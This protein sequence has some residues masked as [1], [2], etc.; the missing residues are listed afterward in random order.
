[1][2]RDRAA[3]FVCGVDDLSDGLVVGRLE[4]IFDCVFIDEVQDLA[5][6]DLDLLDK[7]FDSKMEVICVGDPRQATFSTNRGLKNSKYAGGAGFMKWL[8]EPG[9]AKRL[10]MEERTQS[11]RCN[12]SIC[13]FADALYPDL[14]KTESVDVAAT[15]H[16]GIFF[17]SEEEVPE[18]VTTYA[19][20]VLR[21]DKRAKTLGL[22]ALNF[23]ASKGRT[24]DRILIF[25]TKPMKAYLATND[26]SSA[27]D[28]AKFYVAVTRARFSV[29]FVAVAPH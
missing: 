28:I 21:Y 10:T 7:L 20:V 9:R 15:P 5:S 11:F 14:P 29:A 2:Y 4:R 6:Y 12:Q 1:L 24:Y 8:K 27:G 13:D 25:P 3:E 17:V 18:Y 19:P 22:R 26:L 23:G 16:D